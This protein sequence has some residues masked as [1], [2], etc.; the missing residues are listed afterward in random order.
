MH[1]RNRGP[2]RFPHRALAQLRA[3]I[4]TDIRARDLLQCKW[5]ANE[6]RHKCLTVFRISIWL[7]VWREITFGSTAGAESRAG[8][9]SQTN[10]WH[11]FPASP[12]LRSC[13]WAQSSHKGPTYK[14]P[15][16][17]VTD[18]KWCIA[19]PNAEFFH[20]TPAGR[21]SE[22]KTRRKRNR[23]CYELL[24]IPRQPSP[25]PPHP[26]HLSHRLRPRYQ[27]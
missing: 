15:I 24:F 25:P 6:I 18:H 9:C 4:E 3:C 10:G 14:F 19:L 17:K 12:P 2:F 7:A 26:A 13:G 16:W 20:R 23:G 1:F 21:T 11:Q 27:D 8:N 5:R 22:R